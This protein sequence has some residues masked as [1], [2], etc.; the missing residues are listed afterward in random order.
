MSG[1]DRSSAPPPS[2]PR[3]YHF[4]HI[5]RATLP[6]GLRVL[7]AENHNAPLVSM[8]ALVRSGADHDTAQTAG[9]AS[10]TADLL[11]EGAGNRDAIRLAEDVGLLGGALGTGADW[12]ASYVSLDVLAR[13]SEEA[14]AIFADVAARPTLPEDGLERVRTERLNELLQQRNEPGAIAGKRFSNLLYGTGAYGN[15]VSGNPESVARITID[16][17]RRFYGQH[18]IPNNSSVVV[19]GDVDAARAIEL[20][21]RAL[22]DWQRGAEVPRPAPAPRPIDASRIYVIDRPQAVQS[23]IRVGHLGV[24]RSC[25]DYFP[26]SVMNS[27]FGGV[28]NSRLNLNLRERHGYTYGVRSQFAFRRNAG[29][30]V[31]AAPVRNEVTRESVSEML[32]ELRRIRSGDIEPREL[33]ETKSYLIGVFPASVQTASDVA[34]RLVDMELYGLSEDYFDRYRENIAAVTKEDVER[35]AQKYLDPDRVLIVIVGNASQIREPLG[36][37]GMPVHEMD[38]D[39]NMQAVG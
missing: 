13:T 23:E 33:D 35:V 22:G 11:D 27:I 17:V 18:Y 28:F 4:P 25:E 16:D 36:G 32:S 14:L 9:L 2:E 5:T 15:S 3:P 29:P 7:V 24:P 19:T 12:D 34:S 6:N 39:G 8:R 38:I 31:V 37:L 21:T 1:V 10:L 30:F 20:V 26:L